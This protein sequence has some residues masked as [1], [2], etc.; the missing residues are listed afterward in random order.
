MLKHYLRSRKANALC[1][2]L[3]HIGAVPAIELKM[4]ALDKKYQKKGVANILL[5]SIM[6]VIE[7]YS[8]ECVGA[9][10]I[11]LYSVPV[12]AALNLHERCGFL[13][14]SDIFVTYKSEFNQGCVPMFKVL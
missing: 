1:G 7:H 10:I 2:E 4:F 12:D 6:K 11:L 5:E 9:K 8:A 3:I 13:L 14:S